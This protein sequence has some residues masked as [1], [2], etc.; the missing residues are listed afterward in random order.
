MIQSLLTASTV[1]KSSQDGFMTSCNATMSN[2]SAESCRVKSRSNRAVHLAVHPSLLSNQVLYVLAGP[3]SKAISYRP[4]T[5]DWPEVWTGTHATRTGSCLVTSFWEGT[6]PRDTPHVPSFAESH[7]SIFTLM[8]NTSALAGGAAARSAGITT[9][10]ACSASGLSV[11]ESMPMIFPSFQV[12]CSAKQVRKRA[13]FERERIGSF[14]TRK[15][16]RCRV[17]AGSYWIVGEG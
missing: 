7:S 4:R 17:Y 14:L 8:L 1:F 11:E 16:V 13:T 3:G 9:L 12:D 10:A 15:S 5:S 2:N 6:Y